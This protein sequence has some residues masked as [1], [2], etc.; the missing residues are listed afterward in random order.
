MIVA[1]RGCIGFE[2]R[3]RKSTNRRQCYR[4]GENRVSKEHATVVLRL[5]DNRI[6]GYREEQ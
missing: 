1:R 2:C 6:N 4:K 5:L 3:L